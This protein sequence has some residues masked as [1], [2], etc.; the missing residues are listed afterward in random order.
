MDNKDYKLFTLEDFLSDD[1]F[2]ASV[3]SPVRESVAFWQDFV[4][5]DPPNIS[6]YFVARRY[7]ESSNKILPFITDQEI[8][9]A[10]RM[11]KLMLTATIASVLVAI[12]SVVVTICVTSK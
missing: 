6:E 3:K 10:D 4:A 8:S 2:V 9:R 12:L 5:S 11:S 7:I 1:F